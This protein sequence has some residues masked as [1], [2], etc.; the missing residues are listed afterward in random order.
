MR[1]S[2]QGAYAVFLHC[3]VQCAHWHCTI[4]KKNGLQPITGKLYSVHLHFAQQC[5]EQITPMARWL[6]RYGGRQ[7]RKVILKGEFIGYT[8]LFK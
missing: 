3:A 2:V 4:V 1:Y 7:G 8:F 5:I 6:H